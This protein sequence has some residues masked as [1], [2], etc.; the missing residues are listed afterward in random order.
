MLAQVITQKSC[1]AEPNL[2]K[3]LS[4]VSL[5]VV[6]YCH[7]HLHLWFSASLNLKFTWGLKVFWW[8]KVKVLVA[9]LCLILC[10]SW[11]VAHQAPLSMEF[12]R[13][14]YWSGLLFPSPG[15]LPNP[16]IK[17]WSPALQANS[18]LSE[19]Q[20][21]PLW[22]PNATLNHFSQNVCMW[23]LWASVLTSLF[24]HMYATVAMENQNQTQMLYR[25]F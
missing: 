25:W 20:G 18:L 5:L 12:S 19:P 17:P 6:S 16:G 8:L 23:V 22:W 15:D 3:Y 21:K 1:L 4:S 10:N 9:Q 7:L 24:H 13:Q 2:A 14:E 11:T